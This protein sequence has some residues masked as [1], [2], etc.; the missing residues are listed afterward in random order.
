MNIQRKEVYRML[1]KFEQYGTVEIDL[2]KHNSGPPPIFDEETKENV[3]RVLEEK[4][5]MDLEEIQLRVSNQLGI[6]ASTSTFSRLLNDMEKVVTPTLAPILT[7]KHIEERLKY[8][9]EYIRRN[10]G[11]RNVIFIDEPRGC[12]YLEEEFDHRKPSTIPIFL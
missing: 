3:R 5:P 12:L 6:E 10:Y 1:E 7:A 4:G 8:C 9:N 11:F 2:R